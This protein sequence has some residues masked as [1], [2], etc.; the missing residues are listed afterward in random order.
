MNQLKINDAKKTQQDAV[1]M[2]PIVSL[3]RL[4]EYQISS[5]IS[6]QNTKNDAKKTQQDAVNMNPVASL[7]RLQSTRLAPPYPR[8]ILKMMPKRRNKML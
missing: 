8:R 7:E 4:S 1:K 2:N 3:E 6:S 5:T